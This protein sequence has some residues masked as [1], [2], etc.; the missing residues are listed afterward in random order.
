MQLRIQSINRID[1]FFLLPDRSF[2]H[3]EMVRNVVRRT[4]KLESCE[5]VGRADQVAGPLS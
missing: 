3:L 1:S 2:H 4:F 5:G